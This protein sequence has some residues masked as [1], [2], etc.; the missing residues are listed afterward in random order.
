MWN[1]HEVVNFVKKNLF[2]EGNNM[3]LD[4]GKS[5]RRFNLYCVRGSPHGHYRV[6]LSRHNFSEELRIFQM[7]SKKETS[8]FRSA[9]ILKLC[10]LVGDKFCRGYFA[11]SSRVHEVMFSAFFVTYYK[12]S[13]YNILLIN[14]S[15]Y[16]WT[17]QCFY[18][19]YLS[20]RAFYKSL[21]QQQW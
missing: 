8:V 20:S 6:R 11:E 18:V 21:E 4:L 9:G 5:L 12:F 14:Y 1:S 17:D 13:L 7:S 10:I 3:S 16:V 19:H 2:F 15:Y